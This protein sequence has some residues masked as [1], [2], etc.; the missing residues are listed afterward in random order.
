MSIVSGR[1]ARTR[2]GVTVLSLAVV[3]AACGGGGGKKTAGSSDTSTPTTGIGDTSTTA[4]D[5]GT[6]PSA[7]QAS[8]VR[9]TPSPNP[10]PDSACPPSVAISP[11]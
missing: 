11:S 2:L 10:M 8:S 7:L 1:R 3:A 5:Q 9:S 6:T 4:S